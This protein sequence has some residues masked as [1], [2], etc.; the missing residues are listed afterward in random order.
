MF[1]LVYTMDVQPSDIGRTFHFQ[2][3]AVNEVGE[4]SRT[5]PLSLIAGTLPDAPIDVLKVTADV[6][7]ITISWNPPENDGGTPI[8]N[9]HIYW[10]NAQTS[11]SYGIVLLKHSIGVQ[12]EWS[13]VGTVTASALL[14][15]YLYR[16]AVVAVNDIGDSVLSEIIEI[17][18]ATVPDAPNAPTLVS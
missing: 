8:T 3:T 4:S 1:D 13:T 18:A 16:F 7:Q 6:A 17:H 15:G 9:Y 2:V 5:T 10:D 12:T 11:A 14:D